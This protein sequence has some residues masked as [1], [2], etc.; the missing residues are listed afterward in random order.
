MPPLLA[1]NLNYIGISMDPNSEGNG[2]EGKERHCREREGR[3]GAAHTQM[4]FL[5]LSVRF[6]IRAGHFTQMSLT[7]KTLILSFSEEI[8]KPLASGFKCLPISS[9]CVSFSNIAET[10]NRQGKTLRSD[11]IFLHFFI[12]L[13]S[14]LPPPMLF[15][16]QFL[17]L[18]REKRK[19][20]QGD[21]G[22]PTTGQ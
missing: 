1:S 15:L 9:W 21:T 11:S 10:G 3:W 20:N 22:T 8:I 17:S 7:S 6:R 12:L 16:A 14:C 19:V 2:Q 4:A 18:F 5:L 13:S